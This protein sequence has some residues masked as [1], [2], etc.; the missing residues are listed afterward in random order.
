MKLSVSASAYRD[1]DRAAAFFD[2]KQPGL[3]AQFIIEVDR[4]LAVLRLNPWLGQ[5]LDD[6]WRRV[7]LHQFPYTLIYKFND[8]NDS[9]CISVVYH[10]HRRPEFWRNRV[11][12]AIPDYVIPRAA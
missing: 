7:H 12:E 5:R 10:Q 2:R 4:M 6:T 1:I 8:R 9:I 3:G 11:E